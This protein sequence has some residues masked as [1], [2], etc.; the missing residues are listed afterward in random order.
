MLAFFGC[1]SSHFRRIIF[2]I[3]PGEHAPEPPYLAHACAFAL[4]PPLEN[5]LRGPWLKLEFSSGL[6]FTADSKV[7]YLTARI[8]DVFI[9]IAYCYQ[10]R[11]KRR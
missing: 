2:Q 1:I 7:V 6:N 11:K 8:I 4:A 5:P 9:L 10:L 3:F